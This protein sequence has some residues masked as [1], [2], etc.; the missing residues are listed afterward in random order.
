MLSLPNSDVAKRISRRMWAWSGFQFLVAKRRGV[1]LEPKA[2]I[3]LAGDIWRL[4]KGSCRDNGDM[5]M[6]IEFMPISEEVA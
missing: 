6:L 5:C 3:V 4:C 2:I 1:N